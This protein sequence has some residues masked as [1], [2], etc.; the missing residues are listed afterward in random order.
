MQALQ[1]FPFVSAF[2]FASLVSCAWFCATYVVGARAGTRAGA[3]VLVSGGWAYAASVLGIAVWALLS[4]QLRD[5][6]PALGYGVLLEMVVF[7][8]LFEYTAYFMARSYLSTKRRE[9]L[10][11]A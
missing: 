10:S 7:V 5:F 4:G 6:G 3:I 11:R 1:H 9:E 2:M 8:W